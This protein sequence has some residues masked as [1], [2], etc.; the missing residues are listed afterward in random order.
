M[1]GRAA[2]PRQAGG[3][4]RRWSTGNPGRGSA[5]PPQTFS[6]YLTQ[7]PSSILPLPPPSPPPHTTDLAMGPTSRPTLGPESPLTPCRRP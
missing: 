5:S 1:S 7:P 3:G 6:G 4:A 2:G